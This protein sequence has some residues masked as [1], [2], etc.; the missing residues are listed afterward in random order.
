MNS[1]NRYPHLNLIQ[2]TLIAIWPW[3]KQSNCCPLVWGEALGKLF[4]DAKPQEAMGWVFNYLTY[5]IFSIRSFCWL[6]VWWVFVKQ[7]LGHFIAF[8]YYKDAWN[9][10]QFIL[11]L[12]N[13]LTVSWCKK[14]ETKL[15]KQLEMTN[16]ILFSRLCNNGICQT[17]MTCT[18]RNECVFE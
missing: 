11:C 7:H 6:K 15:G 9:E 1:G 16:Y 8:K 4:P 3:G 10:Q 14:S 12:R 2:Y 13:S 5:Y 18:G 17:I